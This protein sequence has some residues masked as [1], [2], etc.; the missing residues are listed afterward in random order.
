M[1]KDKNRI[2]IYLDE[3]LFGIVQARAENR[4][5]SANVYAKDLLIGAI[6]SDKDGVTEAL[7]L[8]AKALTDTAEDVRHIKSATGQDHNQL[9]ELLTEALEKIDELKPQAATAER[10]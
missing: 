7:N 3:D 5:K 4:G 9:G 2:V 10:G 6:R 1:S 8:I